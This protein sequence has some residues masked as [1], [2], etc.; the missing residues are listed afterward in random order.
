MSDSQP[1]NSM[2]YGQT[3]LGASIPGLTH[4][5]WQQIARERRQ[6]GYDL[7]D[8][9][10]QQIIGAGMLLEALRHRILAGHAATEKDLLPISN[11][12]QAA[13]SEGRTL[14]R[15]LEYN[16]L[17]AP[18]PLPVLLSDWLAT[19]Q[20]Q[21]DRIHF[22]L[23]LAADIKEHLAQLPPQFVGHLIAIVREATSN[24]LRHSQAT[25]AHIILERSNSQNISPQSSPS[26]H[27]TEFLLT[28]RDNGR[29]MQIAGE[30][31]Q[32]EKRHFGLA[33]MQYRTA[34]IGGHFSLQTEP[35]KGTAIQI[36]FPFPDAH[37]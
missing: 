3:Q 24:I 6:I 33:S 31:D 15:R 5:L 17:E 8:D 37:D 12:I 7:H 9:L 4:D 30:G 1:H 13:I 14:I 11:I 25:E 2:E 23:Q 28:I 36:R 35:G 10:L 34:S 20:K 29:G 18:D 26:A 22:H 27:R 16:E 32:E 19:L 21:S